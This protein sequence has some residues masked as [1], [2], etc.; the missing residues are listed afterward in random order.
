[1]ELNLDSDTGVDGHTLAPCRL[2]TNL[3][4]G[5]DCGFVKPV[6]QLSDDA[7]HSNFIRSREL[8]FEYHGALD[9]ERLGLVRVSR[10]RLEE[11]FD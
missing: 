11:N 8:D 2:E 10:L 4:G 9:S 7:Q 5:A 3:F 1:M 6:P